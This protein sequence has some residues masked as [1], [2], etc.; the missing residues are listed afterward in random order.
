MKHIALVLIS[1]VVL[2]ALLVVGCAKPAPA[3]APAPEVIEWRMNTTQSTEA[4]AFQTQL[5]PWVDMINEACEG[6]LHV[7]VYPGGALGFANSEMIRICGQQNLIESFHG[8]PSYLARD[9]PV[10]GIATADMVMRSR[11]EHLQLVPFIVDQLQEIYTGWGIRVLSMYPGSAC[12][13]VIA[14]KCPS[15]TIDSLKGKKI[16]CWNSLQTMTLQKLGI[17]AEIIPRADVYLALKTGV[18]DG[19][20]GYLQMVYV[21]SFYEVCDYYSIWYADSS[22]PGI[23]CSEKAFQEM[24]ADL[25][26]I[27]VETSKKHQQLLIENARKCTFEE[28]CAAKL[29][30][31]NLVTILPPI[32][33]A[34]TKLLNDAAMEVWRELAQERG[35]KAVT[36]QQAVE[37]EILQMRGE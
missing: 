20:V 36:Y 21:D 14:A 34:E 16:R 7:I 37:A 24:P 29:K 4:I 9:D 23:F 26:D 22:I 10:L 17:A 25:R 1:V 35:L 2:V 6:R 11:E 28:E 30:E 33:E 19:A 8:A 3:P 15:G 31:G 13:C 18:M 32:S 5:M 12:H 27:V